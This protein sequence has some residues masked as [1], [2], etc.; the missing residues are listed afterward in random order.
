MR[1][2]KNIARAFAITSTG[3]V[4]GHACTFK[5]KPELLPVAE[6]KPAISIRFGTRCSLF[7]HAYVN[8]N[9]LQVP[10]LQT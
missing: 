7:E 9:V 4:G 6:V 3:G 8:S 1:T 10:Q 2:A 5:G